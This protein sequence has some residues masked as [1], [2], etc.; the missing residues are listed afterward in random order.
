MP[1]FVAFQDMFQAI[2]TFEAAGL[3]P[4]GPNEAYEECGPLMFEIQDGAP[5]APPTPEHPWPTMSLISFPWKDHAGRSLLKDPFRRGGFFTDRKTLYPITAARVKR[6]WHRV[7]A[8]DPARKDVVECRLLVDKKYNKPYFAEGWKSAKQWTI[9]FEK[10]G[11]PLLSDGRLYDAPPGEAPKA[12][13]KPAPR[14]PAATRAAPPAAPPPPASVRPGGAPGTRQP[15]TRTSAPSKASPAPGKG[16]AKTPAAIPTAPSGPPGGRR[17]GWRKG[18]R[19]AG[20]ILP[21][22]FLA[23]AAF[24]LWNLAWHWRG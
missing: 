8:Y 11:Q 16:A 24:V 10:E 1:I 22:A 9:A 20:R 6:Q 14:P 15:G 12:A 18:L 13:A 23:F 2:E 7:Y 17:A 4:H 3:N 5:S 19:I 21:A